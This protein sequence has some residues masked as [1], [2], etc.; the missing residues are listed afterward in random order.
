ML[1]KL[2]KSSRKET[3]KNSV[4]LTKEEQIGHSLERPVLGE[5]S[6]FTFLNDTRTGQF[7]ICPIYT[8]TPSTMN[9]FQHSSE[10]LGLQLKGETPPIWQSSFEPPLDGWNS[11]TQL[12][13]PLY[14][15]NTS[16]SLNVIAQIGKSWMIRKSISHFDV[17]DH[18]I[19][20]KKTDVESLLPW[21]ILETRLIDPDSKHPNRI[22]ILEPY[23]ESCLMY[24]EDLHLHYTTFMIMG[25]DVHVTLESV[26][27]LG[28]GYL[29]TLTT[30]IPFISALETQCK[31]V[32]RYL[33]NK[34]FTVYYQ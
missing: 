28:N 31:L 27:P 3:L 4:K 11:G 22:M 6:S 33:L 29:A 24:N 16:S 25:F 10:H 5:P 23:L 14:S 20:I 7:Q 1:K 8:N 17:N 19:W 13:T 30:M 34:R 26:E 21:T 18:G 32:S 2:S 9:T 12:D 15:E